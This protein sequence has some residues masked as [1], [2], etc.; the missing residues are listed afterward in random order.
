[1]SELSTPLGGANVQQ[2]NDAGKTGSGAASDS[3][4]TPWDQGW[5]K[6][7]ENWRHCISLP[8]PVVLVFRKRPG[9]DGGNVG[10]KPIFQ[11]GSFDAKPANG[12]YL[13]GR[14]STG[15]AWPVPGTG[16]DYQ[17]NCQVLQQMGFDDSPMVVLGINASDI[18]FLPSGISGDDDGIL[19]PSP[20]LGS[21]FDDQLLTTELEHFAAK[22]LASGELRRDLWEKPSHY[23]PIEQAERTIQKFLLICLRAVF[24][25][26]EILAETTVLA[27]RI[28]VLI[29][30]GSSMVPGRVVLELKAVRQFG[31][32]G[33]V[34]PDATVQEQIHLG[35]IQAFT[36]F[37]DA[38]NK[39][40]CLYDMRKDKLESTFARALGECDGYGVKLRTYQVHPT[41]ESVRADI[42]SAVTTTK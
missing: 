14:S 2:L 11:F 12:V 15:N 28:D 20:S 13:V 30:S 33:I 19:I 18:I 10:A 26:H 9:I 17:V 36:Y 41:A 5:H 35:I 16:G 38:T 34:L 29:L 23:W 3:D 37:Q 7:F 8:S 42:A 24:K 21:P 6:T 40:I 27:G 25:D 22:N 39:Y 32:T 4:P 1:M 31:S